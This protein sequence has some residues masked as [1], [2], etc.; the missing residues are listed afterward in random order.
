M[1]YNN[2]NSNYYSGSNEQVTVE[3]NKVYRTWIKLVN[4][5]VIFVIISPLFEWKQNKE[6]N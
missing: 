3:Y 5:I 2:Y 4:V 1:N 6:I